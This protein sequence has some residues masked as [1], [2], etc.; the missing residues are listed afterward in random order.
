MFLR[1]AYFS[2]EMAISKYGYKASLIDF[3]RAHTLKDTLKV[4]AR[5]NKI[6]SENSQRPHF[7]S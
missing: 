5:V 6:R 1:F 2:A 7:E 4:A 3:G